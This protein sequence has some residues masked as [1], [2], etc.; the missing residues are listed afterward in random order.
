MAK[1]LIALL[2]GLL[3]S[4]CAVT[5]HT[6]P[7][8]PAI[9]FEPTATPAERI[10]QVAYGEH[11]AWGGSFID[12][13]GAI[14]RYQVSEGQRTKL[15]D[16]QPAWER[17]MR[18]WQGSGGIFELSERQNCLMGRFDVNRCRAFSMDSAWSA[19]FVSYVLK[20]A[21]VTGFVGSPRHFDYIK[22][23]YQG[24]GVY[25]HAN[26]ATTS[27]AVGDMLCYVRGDNGV[28]GFE[29]LVYY[30]ETQDK[31]LTAHCDIVVDVH[32]DEVWLIGGN[33][34]DTVMLRQ[35]ALSGGVIQ[36]PTG[37]EHC[38]HDNQQACDFNRQNWAVLLK[39]K[40]DEG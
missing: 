40:Q 16:G 12:Q 36:L 30:L 31:W 32:D 14:R 34:M 18:Y 29:G 23:A 7:D 10:R 19:V 38:R 27:P 15:G 22:N 2:G 24:D 6:L 26:P 4:G 20:Q 13:S 25:R 1:N 28:V 33:V 39:L 21:G 9:V 17:V 5:S 8:L 37:R 35:M 3:L 11:Q